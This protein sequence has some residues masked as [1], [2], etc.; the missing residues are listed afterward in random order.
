MIKLLI[1][2]TNGLGKPKTVSFLHPQP[3]KGLKKKVQNRREQYL[4]K[5]AL[6]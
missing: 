2:G 4:T 3:N 6:E 1:T 5:I